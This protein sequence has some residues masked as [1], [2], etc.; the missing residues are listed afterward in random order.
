MLLRSCGC[1]SPSRLPSFGI[2][3]LHL[4]LTDV[5][6]R[7]SKV[8]AIRGSSRRSCGNLFPCD[9]RRA[10]GEG[11]TRAP[12]LSVTRAPIFDRCGR[13]VPR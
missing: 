12:W 5:A 2:P 13:L 7:R 1:F 4:A 9:Q 11:E 10:A 6:L 3:G 8:A